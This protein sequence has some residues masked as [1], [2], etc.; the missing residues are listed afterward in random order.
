VRLC[1]R[2]LQLLTT[3][4]HGLPVWNWALQAVGLTLAYSGAELNARKSIAGFRIWIASNIV[5]GIVHAVTGLWLLLVLDFLFLRVNVLGLVR[6]R[7][8]G[9][10]R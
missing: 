8:A 7:D 3:Q 5:L 10:H 4:L 6:W 2:V 1:C 9:T